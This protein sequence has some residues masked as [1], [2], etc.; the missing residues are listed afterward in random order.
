M[1]TTYGTRSGGRRVVSF[2]SSSRARL[3]LYL[4]SIEVIEFPSYGACPFVR[5]RHS[6]RHPEVDPKKIGR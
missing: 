5:S 6:R 4:P 3:A 2:L 1:N